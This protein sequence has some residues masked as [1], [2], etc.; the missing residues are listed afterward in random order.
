MS[1]VRRLLAVSLA[2]GSVM[3]IGTGPAASQQDP[4]EVIEISGPL[5]ERVIDFVIEAVEESAAQLLVIQLDSPGAV[6]G[7][8]S[9]L[10][11]LVAEPP[12]PVAVWV[13]PAPAVARGGAAQL[14]ATAPI[15]AAAPGADI[16]HLW[17][18]VAGNTSEPRAAVAERFPDAG[19]LIHGEAS[20]GDDEVPI[21]EMIQPTVGQLVVGVD[22]MVV[23]VQGEM[24]ELVTAA[25]ATTDEG[26]ETRKPTAEVQFRKPDLFTRTLRLATRP[27]GTLFFLVTGISL[28]VFEF[29]AAGP[30]VMAVAALMSLLLAGYGMATLPMRWW[31]VG[32]VVVGLGLYAADFQ[33]NDLGWRSLAGTGLLGIGGF[34]FVDAGAQFSTVWWAVLLIVAGAGLFF[35]FGMTAVVRARFSTRTIGRD[36]LVGATGQAETDLDPKGVVVVRGARWR[37]GAARAARIHSGDE[38]RVVGVDGIELEVE[39]IAPG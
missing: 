3:L 19:P 14:L 16:G 22:G 8:I 24:R 9:D 13:G 21:V 12:V 4:V 39:P 15:R 31:A 11:D 26:T 30:G 5:D 20:V 38:V 7:R 29:Y 25:E 36:Q 27:E 33:R 18:T 35:G 2:A 10:I 28:V 37:A 23:E 6:S 32:A 17:P 34:W 1:P